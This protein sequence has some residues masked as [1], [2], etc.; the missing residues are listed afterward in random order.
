MSEPLL[1]ETGVAADAGRLKIR[2]L[3]RLGRPADALVE[4]EHR[5]PSTG[6]DDKPLL[7]EVAIG[8]V[9]PLLKDMREQMRGAAYTALK[10]LDSDDMVPYFEDGLSD[11]AGLV[12]ALAAEGLGRLP[13]G[14]RSARLRK[15]MGDQA[16]IVRTA[17]L[18]ALSRS[19]QRSNL[20][21]VESA[22]KD[23]QPTVR[24]TAGGVLVKFGRPKLLSRVREAA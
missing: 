18:K 22:L 15:A 9:I 12:R 19:P 3:I 7:R 10:E 4:Y 16:A 6:G 8:F 20:A 21:L 23:E 17:T 13:A 1:A 2:S 14:R 5:H 11:G 24:V